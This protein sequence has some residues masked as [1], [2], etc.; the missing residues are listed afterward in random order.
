M[1]QTERFGLMFFAWCGLCLCLALLAIFR[2][3]DVRAWMPLSLITYGLLVGTH[4]L[5]ILANPPVEDSDAT[6]GT[7]W[8]TCIIS[9]LLCW[10]A[11]GLGC[12]VVAAP[13]KHVSPMEAQIVVARI[14]V[15]LLAIAAGAAL[16][17]GKGKDT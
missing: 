17:L 5:V 13:E 7:A 15:G 10:M 9:A 14:L 1:S 6:R 3:N 4:G 2:P 8:I 11:V 12:A 16:H